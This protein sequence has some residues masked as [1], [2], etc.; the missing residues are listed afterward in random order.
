MYT[1]SPKVNKFCIPLPHRPTVHGRRRR[2]GSSC[3]PLKVEFYYF[4]RTNECQLN[5]VP[6]ERK[7]EVHGLI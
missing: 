6:V 3:K 2:P 5:V 7:R 1:F 4:A